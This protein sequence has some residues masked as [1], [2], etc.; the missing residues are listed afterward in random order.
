MSLDTKKWALLNQFDMKVDSCFDSRLE[1]LMGTD[2]WL[3]WIILGLDKLLILPAKVV[4]GL[5]RI[6][7]GFVCIC[8]YY[9]Q[10]SVLYIILDWV[11]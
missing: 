9:V 10:I 1:L 11:S 2:V 4:L 6:S 5:V 7:Y 8:E 3:D